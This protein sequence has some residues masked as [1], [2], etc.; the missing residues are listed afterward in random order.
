MSPADVPEPILWLAVLFVAAF[1]AWKIKLWDFIQA[2]A[3]VPLVI[4]TVANEFSANGGE[5]MRDAVNR[6]DRRT[7]E[8]L[9]KQTAL[10]TEWREVRRIDRRIG[11]VE[12]GQEELGRRMT[13]AE[14][15]QD[16]QESRATHVDH[17]ID[18]LEARK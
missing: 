10:E 14:D 18:A 8:I 1:V 17:R 16:V 9:E 4:Q 11:A 3:R 12:V 13:R 15:R 7:T 5:S 2:A 6:Q